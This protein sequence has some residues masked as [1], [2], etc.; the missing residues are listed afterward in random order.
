MVRCAR[1]LAGTGDWEEVLQ[2]SLSVAWRKRDKFDEA[3]GS[4]RAWL[5][6]LTADQ[7]RKA[8]RRKR[9]SEPLP[10]AAA[11]SGPSPDDRIDIH[12]A[13]TTLS[14]KHRLAIELYYFVDLP[15]SEVAAAM[16]CK[17]GTVKSTLADAR[18]RMRAKLERP[19]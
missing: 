3:R 7:A 14:T 13:L 1:R 5:L 17:E 10:L 6:A 4:A 9:A 18:T 8:A 12:A 2:E 15:I 11:P 19:T 16:G